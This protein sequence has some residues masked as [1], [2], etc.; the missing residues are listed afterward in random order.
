MA[1][2]YRYVTNCVNVPESDVDALIEMIDNAKDTSYDALSRR[3][4]VP[5][6]KEHFP[7]YAWGSERG[8]RMTKDY[9]VSYHRSTFKG[10]RVYYVR[11]SAIEYIFGLE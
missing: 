5:L 7:G 4:G 8:L 9:A 11:W 6:L 1:T 10:K 3:V 2:R